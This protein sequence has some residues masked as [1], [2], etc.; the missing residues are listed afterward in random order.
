MHLE[1]DKVSGREEDKELQAFGANIGPIGMDRV[2][3]E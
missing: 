2:W 1:G 3:V